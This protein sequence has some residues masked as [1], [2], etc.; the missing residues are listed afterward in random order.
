M[1]KPNSVRRSYEALLSGFH[2]VALEGMT[3][4]DRQ[5]AAMEISGVD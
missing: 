1:D 4:L 5:I 3:L 2:R